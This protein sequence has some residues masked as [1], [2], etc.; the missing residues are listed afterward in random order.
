MLTDERTHDDLGCPDVD[1]LL[2]EAMTENAHLKARLAQ[3]EADLASVRHRAEMAEALRT[4]TDK[5]FGVAESERRMLAE[6]VTL[7]DKELAVAEKDAIPADTLTYGAVSRDLVTTI[8][9][10]TS[11]V[12]RGPVPRSVMAA[13]ESALPD[14]TAAMQDAGRDAVLSVVRREVRRRRRAARR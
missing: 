13:V 2:N 1:L 9:R 11:R 6:Q 14:V 4:E 7:L 3:V 5:R 12:A 8:Y 10:Q